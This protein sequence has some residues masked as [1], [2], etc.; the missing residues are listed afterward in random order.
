MGRHIKDISL[1]ELHL[2]LGNML[3]RVKYN[4]GKYVDWL[5]SMDLDNVKCMNKSQF[6][7]LYIAATF[8]QVA[9]ER[10]NEIP[11]KWVLDKRLYMER[12]YVSKYADYLDIYEAYQAEYDHNV[13]YPKSAFEVL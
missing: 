11:P 5:Y 9:F 7:N 6:R 8:V 2:E 13:F 1:N 10:R 12:A 4:T 3:H